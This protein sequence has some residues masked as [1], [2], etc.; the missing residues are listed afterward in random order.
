MQ[1]FTYS[2]AL[3]EIR[4]YAKKNGMTFKRQNA[5]INGKQAYQLTNRETGEV[6]RQNF[7]LWNA[8]SDMQSGFMYN[9]SPAAKQA[10]QKAEDECH[11]SL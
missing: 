11:D 7:T 5:T 10:W 2:Q 1:N 9:V 4:N 8:Y 6:I 3:S